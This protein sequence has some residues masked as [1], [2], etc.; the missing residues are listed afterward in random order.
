MPTDFYQTSFWCSG[1]GCVLIMTHHCLKIQNWGF[2]R[3]FH[4][5]TTFNLRN[6]K[7]NR[8]SSFQLIFQKFVFPF[9]CSTQSLLFEKWKWRLR[10]NCKI[11][12]C[13]I[14]VSASS[15]IYVNG[16]YATTCTSKMIKYLPL[17]LLLSFAVNSVTR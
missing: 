1:S 14:I 7:S 16:C 3:M 17:M 4:F 13:L 8:V 11:W 15:G 2:E 5:L 6:V 10:L 9:S 12:E